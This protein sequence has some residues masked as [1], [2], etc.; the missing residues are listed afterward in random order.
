MATTSHSQFTRSPN[1]STRSYDSSSVS[2]AASPKPAQ[3]YLAA[4]MNTSSSRQGGAP[5]TPSIAVPSLPS[6]N[7]AFQAYNLTSGPVVGRDSLPS[8]DSMV[9]TPGLGNAQLPGGS[10][11]Q[12]QKRAYRQRRK[13]PSCDACRERKVKCDATETTSCSEC[14]S[15]N[16]KCQFTK[17]TNRR[18]SSIKQVQDLEKQI[19][20]VK[21]DNNT[22]RRILEDKDV[23]LDADMDT[24]EQAL[25]QPPALGSEPKRKQRLGPTPDLSRT[26]PSAR[27]YSKGAF[28]LPPQHRLPNSTFLDSARLELPPFSLVGELLRAYSNT[29]HTMFPIIHMP[30]FQAAVDDLYRVSNSQL[31]PSW[32]ALFFSVLAAG[33]LFSQ[34]PPPATAFY[35]PAEL[36]E[37]ARK[38]IDPWNDEWDLEYAQA[39]TLITICL[40]EMN[41]K[42]AAWRWLG[43]AV[44]V[45]QDLGLYAELGPWP[46]IQGEMRRRTWWTIYILDRTLAA[47]LG[48]PCVI[49]DDDCDVSLPA[50]VDDQYIRQ[51]GMLVPAGA[52]P[53]T[54]SLLAV[55]HVARSYT[56][57]F[58]AFRS[59]SIPAAQM[60]MFDDYFKKCLATFPPACNPSSSVPLSPLFLAPLSHL[61]NARLVLHRH[62]LSPSCSADLRLAALEQCTHIALE[63]S[64]LIGR[65][66]ASLYEAATTT[67]VTHMFRCALFL[68][69]AGY[70]DHAISCIRAIGYTESRRDVATPCGRYLSLFVNTLGQKRAEHANYL[71]QAMPRGPF[72]PASAPLEQPGLLGVLARDEELLAYVSADLQ[73][74]IRH[75]WV[76]PSSEHDT[77]HAKSGIASPKPFRELRGGSLG[78]EARSGLSEEE[79]RAWTGWAGLESA[80]R[81]L[82]LGGPPRA[83]TP[84]PPSGPWSTLPP[85]KTKAEV[86]ALG[87]DIP[88]LSD[89]PRYGAELPKFPSPR[90]DSSPPTSTA[91][92]KG[93]DRLS[94]ANII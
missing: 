46:V 26:R 25:L 1:P 39:F 37:S 36:L 27:S 61:L 64:S 2:S 68:L 3:Q 57:I 87:T 77:T 44:R 78:S 84:T 56:A 90:A 10:I 60:V 41:L 40:Y 93:N 70:F 49:D 9:S 23:P 42:S 43:D 81:G 13:D 19:E 80:V 51:D 67:L 47:E 33:S 76:W 30:S 62:H 50:G 55:V 63:T 65:A 4:L 88:R 53:L 82:M 92:R 29:T 20:R 66:S 94:I 69:L 85:L 45:G 91:P 35:Q 48:H 74:S 6:V 73:G 5:S 83:A 54:H 72:S 21:R 52:E 15:R 8:A 38:M 86:Q 58:R 34:S 31:S 7:Q 32:V 18:M 71:M 59:P 11:S 79:R 12:A 89:A 28:K 16:V 17:E 22:L 24:K 14:S 75:A